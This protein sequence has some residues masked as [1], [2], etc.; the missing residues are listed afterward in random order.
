L[1]GSGG[2]AGKRGGKDE[3]GKTSGNV[4]IERHRSKES[5]KGATGLMPAVQSQHYFTAI[6]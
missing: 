1:R 4:A 2:A 6:A 3:E 5:E